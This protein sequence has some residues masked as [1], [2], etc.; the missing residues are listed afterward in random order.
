LV[1]SCYMESLYDLLSFH[2]WFMQSFTNLPP[3]VEIIFQA[4]TFYFGNLI[5]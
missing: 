5:K 1:F 3:K 4:A 2:A